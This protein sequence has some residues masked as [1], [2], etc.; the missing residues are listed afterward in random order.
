[1][2]SAV[3]CPLSGREEGSID[4]KMLELRLQLMIRLVNFKRDDSH[5]CARMF[6]ICPGSPHGCNEIGS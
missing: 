6:P 3:T 2:S 4:L 5:A 1:M